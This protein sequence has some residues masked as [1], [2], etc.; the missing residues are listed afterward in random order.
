VQDQVEGGAAA[1]GHDVLD[2]R[3]ALSLGDVLLDGEGAADGGD[4]DEV[5]AEYEA[6]DR[7]ALD[8]DL[9][10]SAGGGAEVEDGVGRA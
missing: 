5:D 3:A 4:G 8:G 9:H 2:A 6:A 1:L 7:N 10:P